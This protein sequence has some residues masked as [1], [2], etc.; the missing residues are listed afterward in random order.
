MNGRSTM[1]MACSALG[2]IALASAPAPQADASDARTQ[3]A[4][5]QHHSGGDQR[6]KASELVKIVRQAT[7][8]YWNV[9]AAE[10]DNY[11]LMFGCVSGEDSGAMGLHYVNL[12]LYAD[13][14]I[15][16]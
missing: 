11:N 10:S 3:V 8:R 2:V 16:A 5:T 1:Y 14:K 9:E 13:G 12:A 15:D 4:T 6:K 7:A